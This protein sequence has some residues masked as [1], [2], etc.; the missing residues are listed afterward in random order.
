M[1]SFM[2]RSKTPRSTLAKLDR[3]LRRGWGKRKQKRGGE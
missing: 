1:K 2:R 3:V